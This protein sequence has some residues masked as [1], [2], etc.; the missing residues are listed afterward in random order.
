MRL[1]QVNLRGLLLYALIL[2]LISIPVSLAS[3]QAILSKEVDESISQQADQFIQHIKGFEYLD[4]LEI[5]LQ[6]LDQ[7]SHNIHI[8]PAGPE[9][10]EPTFN[11]ITLYDPVGKEN[12]PFRQLTASVAIKGKPYLLTVQMSLVDKNEL[13]TA[14][15]AVQVALSILLVA[16]LLLLNRS[17]SKRLWRPFYKTLDQLKA[18]ELARS[19]SIPVEKSNIIEFNDLN[20]TISHLTEKNQRVFQNQKEFIENAAHE[21]QTP[22]AIFRSKLDILMQSPNLSQTDA[23][24]IMELESTA[25]RMSRLNKNLLLLSKINNDQFISTEDVELSTIIRTQVAGMQVVARPKDLQLSLSLDPTHIHT[26]KTL[27]EVLI[28]NLLNNAFR[29]SPKGECIKMVLENRK[30]SVSNKGTPLKISFPKMT[31]RF[32]KESTNPNSS[33]LGLAIVK[34]ICDSTGYKL[35]YQFSDSEHTFSI[36]FQG[37]RREA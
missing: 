14:I 26:N 21:L 22:I 9:Q 34:N 25:Q 5:D 18:Y 36:T 30:L 10:I 24:T 15:G 6:V 11:T 16:G 17:L 37:N 1:L 31:E 35:E 8:C 2:V 23:E 33:G 20:K 29:Y 12:K 19:E 28:S 13:V 4:D 7:L 3:I 32:V 27:I